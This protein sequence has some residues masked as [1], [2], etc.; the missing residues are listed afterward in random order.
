MNFILGHVLISEV[1]PFKMCNLLDHFYRTLCQ[2]ALRKILSK[3]GVHSERGIHEHLRPHSEC[4]PQS[5][6]LLGFIRKQM[7][8]K[9]L[10]KLES[11]FIEEKIKKKTV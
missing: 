8:W 9:R 6:R 7:S 2:I 10:R 5:W 1:L 3:F 4:A 11:S